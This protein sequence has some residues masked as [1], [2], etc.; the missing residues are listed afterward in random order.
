MNEWEWDLLENKSS[1]ETVEAG[2]VVVRVGDRVRLHP[3]V[4]GDVLDIALQGQIATVESIE[5][6][7]EGAQHVC[8]VLD[9]DPGRDLGMMRQPGHRFF[10]TP[11]EIEPIQSLLNESD[12]VERQASQQRK[13]RILIAGIGNI[14]L[15]DDGF[16]VE[17]ARRLLLRGLPGEVRVVD[18]GIRGLDLVYALQD[19]CE[20]TILVDAYPHGQ[21]PGTVSLIEL[22]LSEIAGSSADCVQPHAMHPLNVLRMALAMNNRP[23]RR[24]LLLGCEPASLG[25]EEGCLGLSEVV[26]GAL[27]EAI[28]TIE[29]A[30][31]RILSEN[32]NGQILN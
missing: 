18:F 8:V 2:G 32:E 27:D 4:G 12:R 11:A 16:G 15:G 5:E 14:F 30:V 13:P 6:D 21:K 1:L 20:T 9:E 26:Q 19:G 17:V 29:S 23:L 7:Y 28:K 31:D 24:V 10:F 22:D 25:G 3:R